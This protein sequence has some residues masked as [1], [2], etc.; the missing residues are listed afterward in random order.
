VNEIRKTIL[1]LIICFNAVCVF[2]TESEKWKQ[3][4]IED[5]LPTQSVAGFDEVHRKEKK[6]LKLDDK[7]RKKYFKKNVIPVVLGPNKKMYMIDHHHFLAA[8]NLAGVK[9]VYYEV[10][11]DL[12]DSKDI[13][14]F[15]NRMKEK[16]WVYLKQN[17]SPIRPDQ[18]PTHISRLIDDPYRSFAA[19]VRDE[20][21]F[22]KTKVPF[23][24]FLWADYY[25]LLIPQSLIKNNR[26]LAVQIAINISSA[27]MAS[28]LPGHKPFSMCL[29][30]YESANEN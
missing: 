6:I 21:A 29:K 28:F 27:K 24:E 13:N 17:G 11:G 4:N 15:W 1:L 9:K 19:Q 23:A 18:L 14:H 2:A 25:R 3:A 16:Q 8:A 5:F 22:E 26:P 7:E 20:G 10:V 12:S 30:T